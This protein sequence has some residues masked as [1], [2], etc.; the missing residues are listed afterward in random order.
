VKTKTTTERRW[1]ENDL[2]SGCIGFHGTTWANYLKIRREGLK[3]KHPNWNN[4]EP[5]CTYFY[6]FHG[7]LVSPHEADGDFDVAL[8]WCVR[9]AAESAESAYAGERNFRRVVS[10]GW[11]SRW[12]CGI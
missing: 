2:V 11:C 9:L 12:T 4:S 1:G 3:Y 6:D 7:I 5:N 8:R 10:A